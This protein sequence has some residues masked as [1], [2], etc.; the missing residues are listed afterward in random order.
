MS[1]WNYKTHDAGIRYIGK[2]K[3][4]EAEFEIKKFKLDSYIWR[5]KEDKQKCLC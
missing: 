5:Q 4:P 1:L 2:V 3:L